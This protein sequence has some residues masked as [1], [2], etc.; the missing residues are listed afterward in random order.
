MHPGVQGWTKIIL[1][2][3]SGVFSVVEYLNTVNN[4][5]GLQYS[6]DSLTLPGGSGKRV[7]FFVYSLVIQ[8]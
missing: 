6:T 4:D 1:Q 2:N 7:D 8:M 5:G 3:Q